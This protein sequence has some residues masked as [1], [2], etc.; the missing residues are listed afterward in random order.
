MYESACGFII[1]PNTKETYEHEKR[2]IKEI[3]EYVTDI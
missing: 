3:Y 2:R 1:N